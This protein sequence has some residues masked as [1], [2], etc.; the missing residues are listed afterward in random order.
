MVV[1]ISSNIPLCI[2]FSTTDGLTEMMPLMDE[3]SFQNSASYLKRS[4]YR[5]EIM[6]DEPKKLSFTD[7]VHCKVEIVC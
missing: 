4:Y 1:N 2:E 7:E 6:I 3:I 5:M